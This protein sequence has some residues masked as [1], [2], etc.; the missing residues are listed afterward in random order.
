[1]AGEDVAHLGNGAI[2]VIGDRL[3]Q[4]GDPARTIALVGDLVQLLC[5]LAAAGGTLNG[6]LN[7]FLGHIQR[8]RALDG[9]PQAEIGVRVATTFA[10]GDG[11]L[12]RQ[13]GEHLAALGVVNALL[14]LDLSPFAVAGHSVISPLRTIIM[15]APGMTDEIGRLIGTS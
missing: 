8:P 3:D 5:L 15:P 6:A 7:V 11:D 14:T 1:V 13:L 4:D 2:A 10:G 9:E 12:A